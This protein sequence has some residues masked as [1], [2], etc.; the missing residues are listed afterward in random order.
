MKIVLSPRIPGTWNQEQF[1]SLMR[2]IEQQV[3]LLAEG[4]LSARHFAMTAAPSAGKFT[5][6]D[7]VWNSTPSAAGFIG[8]VCVTGGEPGTF[9]GFGAI[10]A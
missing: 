8:W 2:E 5:R 3:N 6:G 9:K 1:I 10:E 7:I 4:R